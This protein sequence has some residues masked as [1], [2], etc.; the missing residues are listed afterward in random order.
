MAK[1]KLAVV[2]IEKE[3]KDQ[4]VGQLKAFFSDYIDISGYSIREKIKGTIPA[5]LVVI[6]SS[7]ATSI[8]KP[9]LP[10]NIENI[11]IDVVFP[12]ESLEE[13][14]LLPSNTSAM[15]VDYSHSTAI[16]IISLLHEIGITHID[17][18]PVY[19]DIKE[20]NIPDVDIAI[21]A[22]LLSDVPSR[23][24]KVIDIGW[25]RIGVS[26]LI[27]IATKL[28]FL[29][30]K[31]EEKI[32]LYATNHLPKS[33]GLTK[34]L[35]AS[36][37]VKNQMEVVLEIIDDG[38]AVIDNQGNFVHCNKNLCHILNL[39]EN[40]LK[41]KNI[42]QLNFKTSLQNNIF[43][44]DVLENQLVELEKTGKKLVVTKRE[45]KALDN[46]FGSVFII[47]D[48]TQIESLESQ[49]RKQLSRRGHVAK[50]QFDDIIGISQIMMECI[51]KAKKI[52]SIDATV[53]ITGE[54]GTGKELF[55]QSIHNYSIRKKCPFIAINCA[56]LPSNLL[57]SELFGYEDGAFTGSKKGG[58]RGLFELAHM[59]TLFLDE[60][61]D[62]PLDVQ[63]KLL[64]VLEEREMMRVGGTDII[65]VDVRII[66]A[67]NRKFQDLINDGKLRKDLFYRLNVLGL[68]LPPLRNRKSD[69]P[70]LIQSILT[71]IDCLDKII[72]KNLLK[73]MLGYKWDGNVRELKNCV[74]Y[75]GYLG[76]NT[77]TI[78]DLPESFLISDSDPGDESFFKELH[79]QESLIGKSILE[80]LT[81]RNAGRRLLFDLLIK[82]GIETSEYEIRKILD[83][84]QKKQL[85]VFGKG[86]KG[87]ELTEKGRDFMT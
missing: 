86:K 87:A 45:I 24:T 40:D 82:Q 52:A 15:L 85:L 3:A 19:I 47:K 63:V 4:F 38:I 69:I 57:E 17:F 6:S 71:D 1:K 11:Y 46:R 2:T 39:N 67:T 7:I 10:D 9:Y 28:Q 34:A 25:R 32:I 50:Y 59:G 84:L 16:D 73:V 51:N 30:Q 77:L 14:S 23:A 29:D 27:N 31:L 55:A 12:K 58:K 75:M 70:E 66:A 56:A 80:I 74:E 8:V 22:G 62:I 60:V 42:N 35:Q 78:R 43:K 81:F 68:C 53:L 26:T 5:D 48:V 72:D 18:K 79:H 41:N 83:Y 20:E 44:M 49:L 36:S 33:Q 37:S 13:V 65:P 61:G 21:T 64:R 54:T 76:G